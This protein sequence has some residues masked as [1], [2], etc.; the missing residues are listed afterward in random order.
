MKLLLSLILFTSSL[1]FAQQPRVLLIDPDIDPSQLQGY[2]I[3]RPDQHYA[4]PDRGEREQV[5]KGIRS[6]KEMD[7][8]ER[9]VLFMDLKSLPLKELKKKYPKI[10]TAELVKLKRRL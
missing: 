3:E 8:L 4:L 9:D 6:V 10:P 2:Q 1:A 7:E 5:L